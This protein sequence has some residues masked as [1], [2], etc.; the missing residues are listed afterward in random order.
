MGQLKILAGRYI[1]AIIPAFLIVS[2]GVNFHLSRNYS[3]Q[4]ME[5]IYLVNLAGRQ[6]ML[7]QQVMVEYLQAEKFHR[8]VSEEKFQRFIDSARALLYGGQIIYDFDDNTKVSIPPAPNKEISDLLSR[9][10]ILMSQLR[11][12]FALERPEQFKAI[13]EEV[14]DIA[15]LTVQKWDE[16]S[17]RQIRE[18]ALHRRYLFYFNI[19]L[20]LATAAILIRYISV[21][22]QMKSINENVIQA[23]KAK[24]NFFASVSHEIR[25]PLNVVTAMPDLLA[26]T[27]LNSEQAKYVDTLRHTSHR[28]LNLI[29]DLLDFSRLESG[30][31]QLF[32]EPFEVLPFTERIAAAAKIKA[33][34]KDLR[35]E[36]HFDS[37]IPKFLVGDSLR[38]GQVLDNFISNAIRFTDVGAIKIWVRKLEKHGSRERINFEVSDTGI[39]I[40]PEDQKKLFDPFFQVGKPMQEKR[41]GTGLGLA[42][43]QHIIQNM[44]GSIRVD[45]RRNF[46]S[47]FSFSLELEQAPQSSSLRPDN[48]KPSEE[49]E[50]KILAVDDSID[51]LMV[52][53]GLLSPYSNMKVTHASCGEFA[54][55]KVK[56]EIF[57]LILMDIQMPVMD[58]VD[59]AR[60]IQT[61]QMSHNQKLTPIVALTA[62]TSKDLSSFVCRLD[63]PINQNS[64][65]ATI[66]SVL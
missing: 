56:N 51:N 58:G 19:I 46:G 25:N 54:L 55:A 16:E 63:K 23:G 43:C 35:F 40:A 18:M 53:T 52:V 24:T 65:I 45:S 32:N 66:N 26:A 28:L 9:Q 11:S 64:L 33:D 59:A 44:G 57:D 60:R 3:H 48:I 22:N 17:S 42:I 20:S 15:N 61:W 8:R 4:D 7:N 10:I 12:P 29:N 38:I 62:G 31:I 36:L 14:I 47:R 21:S 30:N 37:S 50:I 6:R 39:G 5:N 13:Y 2:V 1:S 49:G 41:G 27:P 34:E